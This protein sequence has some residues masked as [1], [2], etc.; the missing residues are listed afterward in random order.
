MLSL[1]CLMPHS[2]YWLCCAACSEEAHEAAVSYEGGLL[3]TESV[4]IGQ[5]PHALVVPYAELTLDEM[6]GTGAE[7]KVGVGGHCM[8]ALVRCKQQ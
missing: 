7:G 2:G 1:P 5:I 6:I 4:P 8:T 3:P